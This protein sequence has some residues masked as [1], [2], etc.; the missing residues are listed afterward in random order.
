MGILLFAYLMVVA[1]FVFCCGKAG[2]LFGKRGVGNGLVS[3]LWACSA[4]SALHVLNVIGD[5]LVKLVVS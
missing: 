5:V 4:M 1:G 3:A 2:H